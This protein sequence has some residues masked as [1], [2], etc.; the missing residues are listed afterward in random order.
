VIPKICQRCEQ[1]HLEKP[2]GMYWAWVNADGRRRAWKQ[3]L[4]AEC[5][6]EHV[7]PLIIAAE[8]PVLI[9]PA[10]GISTVEDMDAVF[11][12]YCLPGMPQGQSEMPLCAAC[13]VRVRQGALM[14]ATELED[15]GIGVGGPQPKSLS[16]TSVWDSLGLA[17]ERR[18]R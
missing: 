10:C 3:K 13:A 17:P 18:D 9:C 16:A 11:L 15:R 12:T 2:A 7:V 4:C 14:G 8:Q 6:R 5:F 1:Q